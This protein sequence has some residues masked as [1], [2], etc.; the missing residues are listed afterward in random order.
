[1]EMSRAA[2]Q[3]LPQ[4]VNL[5]VTCL[6]D[7]F[8]P[9]VGISVVNV[10]ESL[11]V[12]VDFPPDQTCCA[13][14]AFNSG[15]RNG[16]RQVAARFIDTFEATE[17][18]IVCPSGS[19]VA[20]VRNFYPDLFRDDPEKLARVE[21]LNERVFEFTEFL[22]DVLGIDDVSV[23]IESRATYHQCC[24]LLRELHIEHQPELLLES[25][26]GLN[27][28]P[29]ERK[30]VCCGFGGTFSLKM[31]DISTAMLDEKLDNALATGARTLVAGDTGCIM[32]MQGGLRRR[33]ADV[34]VVHIAEVLD[35]KSDWHR[36]ER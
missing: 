16:A 2:D 5:F 28:V 36:L 30:E 20:M 8:V 15:F 11:G 26:S 18:P 21:K 35:E 33:G 29:M 24:H 13:Q 14:P 25:V 6:V 23:E 7:E 4:R 34:Q 17:G 19:C 9:K 12:E 31:S 10:L 3:P 32:H 27:I 22:V 1:M